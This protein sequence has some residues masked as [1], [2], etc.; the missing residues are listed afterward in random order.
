M[1]DDRPGTSD[2]DALE[3]WR[4]YCRR[5]E[6][7]GERYFAD[8]CS[9]DPAD[10]ADALEHL[11]GQVLCWTGWSV[12]HADPRRPRFQRQNDPITAWG[13]PNAENV[14]RHAR[15]DAGRR[16]VVRGRMH[17]CEDFMLAVR[18]GFMHEPRWG[19]VFQ[20]AGSD[21]DIGR[22][23]EF[24]LFVGGDD[25]GTG[26]WV[27]L[28][29]GAAMVTFRE[30]Y[31]D[32]AVDEPMAMTIECI[33]DDA[34]EPGERLTPADVAVRLDAAAT[35]IEHS[36]EYWIG[37]MNDHRAAGV[38][39]EF[40]PPMSVAKGLEVARY[41]FCF[42]NLAEDEYLLVESDV[43]PARYWSFHCYDMG[44]YHL[45]DPLD[46]QSSLDHTQVAVDGDGRLR[47]VCSARDPGVANWLD[48]G[49]RP[50][51]NLTLR[52]FWYEGD[53]A[54]T[55]R[56]VTRD[57]LDAVLPGDTAR[58]DAAARREALALRRAHLGWRFRT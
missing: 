2:V 29:D 28:P 1:T 9:A 36:V 4:R 26:R 14:Y 37:Y 15:V 48:T 11:A 22:G 42:W 54:I 55:T 25:P 23:D 43:P 8:D 49:G 58:V 57:E 20:V 21:L 38:D 39:N 33:D 16:Y 47:L 7:L 40:A 12:F 51:G 10:R 52:W 46:R 19:T 13:G 5:L 32:W 30:Y 50:V 45:V 31:F 41:A 17:S 6:A 3:A 18:L 35:G 44:R 34:D 27:P 24:E 53:P 56:V